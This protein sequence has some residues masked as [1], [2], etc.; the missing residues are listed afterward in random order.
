[1]TSRKRGLNQALNYRV[2]SQPAA[3]RFLGKQPILDGKMKIYG[4]EMLFRAGVTN[5]FSGDEEQATRQ[6][7]DSC[8]LLAPDPEAG[9]Y[10]VN[11]TKSAL[12]SGIVTLLSPSNTVLEILE[13]VEPDAEL[14]DCCRALKARGY[15]FALDDFSPHESK[16]PFLEIAD[17]IKVDFRM[18]DAVTRSQIYEMSR[19]REIVFIAEKVETAAD[20]QAAQEEGCSLFQG[21]YFCK[22]SVTQSR[23]IPQNHMIHLQLLA[24]LSETPANLASVEQFVM[25]DSAIC[26]RLL[27]LVNSAWYGIPGTI[28]SVRSALVLVGDDEM[29]NLVTVALASAFVGTSSH[30][31]LS[32]AL[33]RAK[34]CELLAPMLN[35][36]APKLYLLGMLSMMDAF[37][38]LPMGHVVQSLPVDYEMKAALLGEVG[39][40]ATALSIAHRQQTGEA[41]VDGEFH[42]TS[43]LTRGVVSKMHMQSV[44]WADAVM[45]G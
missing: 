38:G 5:A 13:N 8:L 32:F 24:C 22:P 12:T 2:E 3:T 27:R 1:M 20:L 43:E 42:G 28:T 11:C 9:R 7:I 35:R 18:S 33:E 31:L 29:R 21:Y 23:V 19:D 10:F 14:L 26:Y 15:R 25:A 6:V 34:L 16:L 40:L 36:P 45:R 30:A 41:S 4:H 37:L 17:Y 39:P 44:C